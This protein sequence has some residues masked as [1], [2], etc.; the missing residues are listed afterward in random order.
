[1]SVADLSDARRD[2]LRRRLRGGAVDTERPE[3]PRRPEGTPPPLSPVQEPLWFMEHFTPG[4]STYTLPVAVRLRGPLDTDR[5]R[6]LL[7]TLPDRH[8]SLRHRFPATEDGRPAVHVVPAAPVPLRL[9][10][11]AT[12]AEAAE[13]IGAES[14]EPLDLA[15][16]PLLRAT[17]I[18]IAD[19]EHVLALFVHHIAADGR[20]TQLLF[21]DLLAMYRG[22]APAAPAVRYGDFALWQRERS[23]ERE[24]T[25]WRGELAGLPRAELPSDRPRPPRLTFDGAS[26]VHRLDPELVTALTGLGA[27]RGAT[28]FMTLLAAFQVLLARYCGRDDL[29]VGTPVAG[30]T[31]DGLDDVVGMFVNTLVLRAR[32]DGDPGF[33]DLVTRTRDVVIDALDHQELPFTRL[34]DALDVPRDPSRQ[35]L[36]DALFSMHDFAVAAGAAGDLAAEDFAMAPGSAR[37]DIELYLVP[38]ADG[39]MTATFTYRTALFDAATVERMAGHLENLLRDAVA[40]PGVPVSE[41]E[42]L[43]EAERRLLTEEWNATAA[44]LPAGATLH[45]LVEAQVARSPDALAVTFRG[46]SL[47]YRELD[48]RAAGVARV[49]RGSGAGPGSLVAVCAERS[50]ELVTG[51]LGVLKT[52][53]AYVPLD[54]DHPADRLAFMLSDAGAAVVLTQRH[55]ADRLTGY[56]AIVLALD[57]PAVWVPDAPALR[58]PDDPA[59]WALDTPAVWAASGHADAPVGVG[60]IAPGAV[61]GADG[62]G[63]ASGADGPGGASGADGPGGAGGAAEPGADGVDGADGPGDEGGADGPG[64]DGADGPGAAAYMIYTSGSTGR[65]KGVPNSHRGIVNRL[66]WMQRRYGLTPD[67]VVLQKTPAGFDVSVWEFFWPL[68][69]GARMVLAEPGGHRD[70]AYLRDLVASEGVT[71]THFVPS[72]LGIFLSEDGVRD[73]TSL[74]RVICSGEEL[75]VDLA[76]RCLATLPGAELHN[77]YGPTEAAI[78]V[79]SWHCTAEALAGRT[80]VPIGAPIQN[81]ALHVLD[82]HRRPV[83]V[84]VPGELHIGGIGV[85]LGYHRRPELTAERFFPLGR[86]RV[87]RT[88]DAARWL[89]DGTIEFLGRLDDQVKLHGLRIELGEIEA[90]LRERAGVRDAA[91]IVREDVPGDRRLVA[92]LVADEPP[93]TARVRVALGATLPDYM[94]PS[95]FVTLDALP[96]TP[97]GKLDRRALPVPESPGAAEYVEPE[98]DAERAIAAVWEQV[99]SVERVGAGDDFFDLGGNSLLAIQVVA[100]LRRALPEGGPQVGLVDLFSFRTVRELAGF[101]GGPGGGGVRP[102]LQRL[103]PSRTVTRS[104]VCVPYGSGSAIVY[105]PLADAL[106]EDQALYAVAIPGNDVGLDEEPEEFDE[107]ARR[108]TEE[109]LRTVEGPVVIYGHCGVGAGLATELARRVEAAGREVE[110]VYIGAIFPFARPRGLMRTLSRIGEF[111]SLRRSQ[112]DINWLKARGVDLEELDPGVADRIVRTMRHDGK[113]AEK[114]FTDLFDTSDRVRLRAPVVSV[115][116]ERDPATDFYEERFREWQFIADTAAL[117]VLDEGGHFFLRYR[118]EELAGIL[119]IHDRLDAPPERGSDDTWWVHG[120]ARTSDPKAAKDSVQPSMGRFLTFS[121]GQQISMIGSALTGW[122]LPLTVLVD[123][124]SVTQFSILAVLNLAGLLISPLAGAIVDRGDRRRVILLADCASAAIQAVLAGIILFG[125]LQLWHIYLLVISLSVAGSFQRLAYNSAVPQ[126]VPKHYL[127]HAIG[128]TQMA[129]GVAQLVV[130]LIAAGL[131]AWIGL[132]GIVAIDVASYVFAIAVVLLVRFPDTLP[133]RPREPLTTEI[134]KGFTYTWNERGLRSMLGFFAVLNIFLSPLLLLV[135]PLVLSFATLAD[136]SRISVVSGL[137]VLLGGLTMALWGGPPKR[138][139]RGVLVATLA[140]AAG[141]VV[142]GLSPSL[143]TIG[144]GAFA[145]TFFLTVMNSIYTTIVQIKVPHRYHGRVFALN[146]LV[147][148]STLPIG[149]GLVA[150]LGAALLDPLLV[151]G[152]PLAATV[153]AVIGVGPGRGIGL[154]YLVCALGM[155]LV[156]AGSLRVRRLVRLD[157]EMPDALPDDQVGLEAIEARRDSAFGAAAGRRSK[158]QAS[159]AS[160]GRSRR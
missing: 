52:G 61:G 91:V 128:V 133:W 16:G 98:N 62:P 123:S 1:M 154:L 129:G 71:T 132:G 45:G 122:A 78:D 106:P 143:V 147:A 75:P 120:V 53:A 43:G 39:G 74:R 126:L 81:I 109:I 35:P 118:A 21:A 68:M 119:Q 111:E 58:V 141:S 18:R 28:R 142:V 30:R 94:V 19:D 49:L 135:S 83:P 88:G 82:P 7:A 148:W 3:I 25:F 149:M 8:E 34:V 138:R 85:A 13:L 117:V 134:A 158:T 2:L 84:G 96:L 105:Q 139:F 73:L 151:P 130:P 121:A 89:P 131:L 59:V 54:P 63:G 112:G 67:D 29:A 26:H 101:V 114:Y 5:L 127:G 23:F 32:L 70:P 65:P 102:L 145:L 99:L 80:S 56:D 40:R 64:A 37:Y 104:Y 110:A 4:T 115:I 140:M 66:D 33:A 15:E 42:L 113:A 48:E 157:T 46:E 57:D 97:N 156:V 92:Y 6:D 47:T 144:I 31:R 87:Y 22:D 38:A 116:G 103:T 136:V 41:L 11:A 72:M 60:G 79:S 155:A 90:A 51:L 153:G 150:P 77:L 137:G 50:A 20:S 24:L 124:G 12:D 14:A 10:E 27:E 36:A 107:V 86:D 125:D 17:L 159:T 108:C 44:D 55:L 160:R 146:T 76:L 69:T 9:A 152:G 95:M 93:E 100:K